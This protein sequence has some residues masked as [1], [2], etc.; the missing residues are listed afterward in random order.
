MVK[1]KIVYDRDACIGAYACTPYAPELWL[2]N[3][4]D[5]KADLKGAIF[6]KNTNRWELIIDEKDFDKHNLAAQ[7][8]PVDVIKL[9]KIEE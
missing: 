4:E 6:N 8:C 7:A 3:S 5:N 2:M 1:Y 9:E